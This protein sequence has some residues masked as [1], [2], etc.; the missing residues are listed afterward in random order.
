MNDKKA[1]TEMSIE[2]TDKKKTFKIFV[3]WHKAI[4][5][6]RFI[7]QVVMRF[8]TIRSSTDQRTNHL[9][10][11]SQNEI[12][13]FALDLKSKTDHLLSYFVTTQPKT[14]KMTS[15]G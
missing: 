11:R 5:L 15:V 6:C 8:H 2:L 12:F 3:I 10:Y 13:T 7:R 4:Q 14:N 1:K 9:D